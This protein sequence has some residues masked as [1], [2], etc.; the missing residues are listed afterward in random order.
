MNNA[1][2]IYDTQSAQEWVSTLTRPEE[3]RAHIAE[4]T[5]GLA[6][7]QK[8]LAEMTDLQQS[9]IQ[10]GRHIKLLMDSGNFQPSAGVL[11]TYGVATWQE[12][13]Y[14]TQLDYIEEGMKTLKDMNVALKARLFELEPEAAEEPAQPEGPHADTRIRPKTH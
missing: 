13:Q 3:I 6:D 9:W 8:H 2:P 11:E 12:G 10:I 4:N 1:A 7:Q 5:T 14:A